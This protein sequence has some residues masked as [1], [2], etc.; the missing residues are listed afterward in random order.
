MNKIGMV[1]ISI[2]RVAVLDGQYASLEDQGV[3]FSLCLHLQLN[4][5]DYSYIRLN[6][7]PLTPWVVFPSPSSGKEAAI[8]EV[9][10]MKKSGC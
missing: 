10:Q 3:P 7:L 6:G 2:I 4:N 8:E 5:W 1:E 9:K